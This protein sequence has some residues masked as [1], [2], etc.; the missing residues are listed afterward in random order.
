MNRLSAPVICHSP[1]ILAFL[2]ANAVCIDYALTLLLSGSV[3][4]VLKYEYSPLVRFSLEHG[5][6]PIYLMSLAVFYYA[7]AYYVLR[8]L[9]GTA[10]YPGGI[11]IVVLL[12]LTHVLGGLSWY[13]RSQWYSNYVVLLTQTT[14][15]MAFFIFLYHTWCQR[16]GGCTE[17]RPALF[18]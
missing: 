5:I 4:A 11:A 14:L 1:W 8:A 2:P 15:L 18:R 17:L 6:F 16:S 13:M 7:C 9:Q 12:S 10:L 3:E